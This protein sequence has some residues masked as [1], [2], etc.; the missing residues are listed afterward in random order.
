MRVTRRPISIALVAWMVAGCVSTPATSTLPLAYSGRLAVRAAASAH[1][2]ATAFSA[3]FE[4]SGDAIHGR[5][6]LLSP[7]GTTLADAVWNPSGV[8]LR[9]GEHLQVFDTLDDMALHVLGQPVPLAALWD[10]LE[11]RPHANA[12]ALPLRDSTGFEQWGWRIDTSS[13]LDAGLLQASQDTPAGPTSLRIR[14]D[15]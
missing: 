1:H 10:W 14:L 3:R 2:T 12:P 11:G 7:L 5:L 13:L 15:R 9:S 6:Q 4:L 8:V